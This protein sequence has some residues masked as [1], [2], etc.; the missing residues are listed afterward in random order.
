MYVNVWHL[1]GRQF[2]GLTRS[3]DRRDD[4]AMRLLFVAALVTAGCGAGGFPNIIEA[5]ELPSAIGAPRISRVRD[6][7]T[8]RVPSEG[9]WKGEEDGVA[10]PGELVLIEGD[11]FGRQPTISIGGRATGL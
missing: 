8:V 9:P 11:N 4:A 6:A 5:R 3:A 10:T 7:G 1:S 2:Q